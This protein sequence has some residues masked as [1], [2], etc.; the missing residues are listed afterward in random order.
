MVTIGVFFFTPDFFKFLDVILDY[1]IYEGIGD[2]FFPR[3]GWFK[4][5]LP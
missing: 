4:G 5:I 2:K 3:N 1:S